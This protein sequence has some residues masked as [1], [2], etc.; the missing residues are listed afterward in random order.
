MGGR[1]RVQVLGGLGRIAVATLLLA[2]LATSA[3]A[4]VRRLEVL[5]AVSLS[6]ENRAKGTPRE[7][8]V[9]QALREGVSRV[10][11]GLLVDS[12]PAEPEDGSNPLRTALGADMVPFTRSFRIVEDQGERPSLFNDD[13][14][15]ATEYVVVVEVQVDVDRVRER[16]VAA[17]LLATGASE[18]PLTGIRLEVQ[19]ITHFRG[20]EALVETIRGED[21]RATSV[22]PVEFERG[23]TILNVEAEWG[24]AELL[25]RLLAAAPPELRILP[26]EI[27]AAGADDGSG[28]QEV[29]VLGVKWTP[30]ASDEDGEEDGQRS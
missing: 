24:A 2:G 6:P 3:L 22:V 14:D 30:P 23:R 12:E 29:L 16:L 11:S 21:V 15:A 27:G 8:A 26:I 19:G 1:T 10:A 20:L 5:G 4:E 7:L 28:A 18:T 25:E 17:G 9:K 13:P